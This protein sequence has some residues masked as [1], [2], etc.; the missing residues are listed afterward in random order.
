M[1]LIIVC[2]QP[3]FGYRMFSLSKAKKRILAKVGYNIEDPTIMRN[4]KHDYVVDV[5]RIQVLYNSIHF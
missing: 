5:Y 4:P 2:Y 1:E 3:F